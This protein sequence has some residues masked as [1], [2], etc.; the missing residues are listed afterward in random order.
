MENLFLK[1][2][3][4]L[5]YQKFNSISDQNE[6]KIYSK[7]IGQIIKIKEGKINQHI[8][9]K[10]QSI[11][12]KV[13]KY[14]KELISLSNME[15]IFKPNLPTQPRLTNESYRYNRIN[16]IFFK[17][18][19]R[20]NDICWNLDRLIKNYGVSVIIDNSASCFSKISFNHAF[21]TIR[22]F[23]SSLSAIDL[24]VLI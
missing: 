11:I 14:K 24:H 19:S 22:M 23:L 3:N 1:K 2:L 21:K 15:I 4:Y 10:I 7:N 20:S 18:W 9:I 6:N 16:K 12:N 13:Y 8:K 5:K 17:S